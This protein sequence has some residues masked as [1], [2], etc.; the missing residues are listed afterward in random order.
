M[1]SK[2]IKQTIIGLI[3]TME[4][5]T[6][7]LP[8]SWSDDM[9]M[10][11]RD[12]SY[13]TYV[14]SRGVGRYINIVVSSPELNIEINVRG[15]EIT[16]DKIGLFQKRV[17]PKQV[18]ELIQAIYNE[19]YSFRESAEGL[20]KL[21]KELKEKRD[22]INRKKSEVVV[23]QKQIDDYLKLNNKKVGKK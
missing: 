7:L 17:Q 9:Q 16:L 14:G 5:N 11:T 13:K 1:N 21:R 6:F 23:I 18:L 12:M 22:Y 19:K 4:G 15:A 8:D 10:S 2:E 20:T 3:R